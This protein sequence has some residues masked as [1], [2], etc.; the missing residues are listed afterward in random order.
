[1]AVKASLELL[2]KQHSLELLKDVDVVKEDLD[3]LKEMCALWDKKI[4][5]ESPDAGD[6]RSEIH[7]SVLTSRQKVVLFV[8]DLCKKYKLTNEATNLINAARGLLERRNTA[9]N[10]ARLQQEAHNK[11]VVQQVRQDAQAFLLQEQQR[12]HHQQSATPAVGIV[13]EG[14]R[15]LRGEVLPR[16]SH[17]V[18]PAPHLEGAWD[19]PSAQYSGP[20]RVGG[21]PPTHP[22]PMHHSPH[23]APMSHK[24]PRHAPM[25]HHGHRAASP[26]HV[27]ML[28][29]A[30]IHPSPRHGPM[31]HKSPRH[32]PMS[33]AGNSP[34]HTPMGGHLGDM[35]G[36]MLPPS[37]SAS[38]I[39]SP[40]LSHMKPKKIPG[41]Y[42]LPRTLSHQCPFLQLASLESR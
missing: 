4:Q 1:M 38:W 24:L 23:H 6:R 13:V 34:R 7:T 8:I 9:N 39:K 18:P 42:L 27:S 30:H 25:P 20:T 41:R 37:A 28:H 15:D 10:K 17:R 40:G 29:P 31:A 3:K 21:L 33:H 36:E 35:R 2:K 5:N 14:P 22:G 16:H 19:S 32:M 11:A 12:H 26:R